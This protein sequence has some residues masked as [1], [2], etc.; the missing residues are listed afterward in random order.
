M[1]VWGIRTT[2]TFVDKFDTNTRDARDNFT[3]G[4]TKEIKDVGNFTDGYAIQKI[5]MLM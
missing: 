4:Q 5:E 3:S 2:S 1:V